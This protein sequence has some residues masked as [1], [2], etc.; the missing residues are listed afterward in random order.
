MKSP[1]IILILYFIIVVSGTIYG[2]FFT[3][4]SR[5]LRYWSQALKKDKLLLYQE[6]IKFCDKIINLY[7]DSIVPFFKKAHCLHSLDRDSLARD[8]KS[9]GKQ[10][11]RKLI[12]RTETLF[13][14][15]KYRKVIRMLDRNFYQIDVINDSDLAFEFVSACFAAKKYRKII[16]IVDSH[17]FG[18][19]KD[20]RLLFYKALALKEK[21]KYKE[22]IDIL[23]EAFAY[24]YPRTQDSLG[25]LAFNYLNLS[26]YDI[27]IEVIDE[28]L[29]SEIGNSKYS[30]LF[31][32]ATCY[33]NLGDTGNAQKYYELAEKAKSN[34][35]N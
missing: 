1:E 2:M 11:K 33:K 8:C 14:K 17:F 12:D 34:Y 5:A 16:K 24:G 27:A 4:E 19:N 23:E 30:L 3:K 25:V 15:E 28:A 20:R 6:S 9:I 7:P 13:N 35:D 21:R 18:I 10:N 22:S 32:K 31:N 26:K 29:Y